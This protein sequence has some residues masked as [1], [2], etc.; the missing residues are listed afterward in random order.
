MHVSEDSILSNTGLITIDQLISVTPIVTPAITSMWRLA[1]LSRI[2]L[3]W[4]ER[5]EGS[6]GSRLTVEAYGTC[7]DLSFFSHPQQNLLHHQCHRNFD[8]TQIH[9]NY[10]HNPYYNSRTTVT[11]SSAPLLAGDHFHIQQRLLLY[12]SMTLPTGDAPP[13]SS[14]LPVNPALDSSACTCHPTHFPTIG[15][16]SRPRRYTIILSIPQ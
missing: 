9:T 6:S 5:S 15:T 3:I 10:Q 13:G 7:K 12:H 2:S 16:A 1:K 8:C 4:T 11:P 14:R